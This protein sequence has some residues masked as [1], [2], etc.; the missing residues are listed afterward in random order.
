[1]TQSILEEFKQEIQSLELQPFADGRFEVFVNGSRI[2]S[3]LESQRFPE[4]KEIRTAL[5][6]SRTA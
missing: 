3:K 5:V 1:L 2:F 6:D 4:Y